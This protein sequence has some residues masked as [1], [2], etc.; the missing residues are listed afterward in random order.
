MVVMVGVLLTPAGASAYAGPGGVITGIG[1]L[2]ALIAGLFFAVV[3]FIWL[4]IKRL[5]TWIA[6]LRSSSDSQ[7]HPPSS[8]RPP[9]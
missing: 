2:L 4:P 7:P 3:G 6:G 1:A 5:A 8:E 9:G